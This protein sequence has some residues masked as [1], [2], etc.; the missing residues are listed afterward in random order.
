MRRLTDLARVRVYQ[1]PRDNVK[2]CFCKTCQASPNS[3]VGFC[4]TC[5][6]SITIPQTRSAFQCAR[7]FL[8]GHYDIKLTANSCISLCSSTNAVSIS[9]ASRDEMLSVAIRVN[10]PNPRTLVRRSRSAV[11]IRRWTLSVGCLRVS[12]RWACSSAVRAGDS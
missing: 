5:L 10:N 6:P 8:R 12:A 2:H 9:S 3:C 7:T 1:P 4:P 11:K